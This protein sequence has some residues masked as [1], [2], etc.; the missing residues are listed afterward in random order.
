LATTIRERELQLVRYQSTKSN[1][2]YLSSFNP[3]PVVFE[4]E[5]YRGD[6]RKDAKDKEAEGDYYDAACDYA[7]LGAKDTA[8]FALERAVAAGQQIDYVKL[9]PDLDSVRS[10]SR[11]A[12][13]L[14]RTKLPQ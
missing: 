8:L 2:P 5:G 9:G 13:L 14:R 3:F 6:L 12:D 7:L 1:T 11:Y 10:D 4:K